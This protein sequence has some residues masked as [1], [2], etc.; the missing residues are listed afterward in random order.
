M[1]IMSRPRL[2]LAPLSLPAP[3]PTAPERA[4]LA[5]AIAHRA[6]CERVVAAL[7]AAQN[8]GWDRCEEAQ[9]ALQAAGAALALAKADAANFAADEAVGRAPAH[10]P[11]VRAAR[12]AMLDAED[13][14]DLA[15]SARAA[16]T[17]RLDE[18]RTEAA[19]AVG[20]ARRAALEVLRGSP[21]IGAVVARLDA[22]QRD[23]MDAGAALGWLLH[24][25][26][27]DTAPTPGE[28][29]YAAPTPALATLVHSRFTSPVETW[30]ALA[31][32]VPGAGPWDAALAALE[33]DAN[34]E[35]PA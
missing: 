32:E 7:E 9:R 25:K 33:R 17:V 23:M 14:L 5:E 15:R 30:R 12:A 28:S 16:L 2:A 10:K 35:L 13:A 11:D 6:E 8:P 21:A 4:A 26:L 22:A 24:R 3:A 20:A 31:A 34:S 29:R 18:A 27:V 1:S 19:E